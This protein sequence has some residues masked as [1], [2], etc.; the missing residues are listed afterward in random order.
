MWKR[1]APDCDPNW[2]WNST[3]CRAS[4][5]IGSKST[6]TPGLMVEGGKNSAKSPRPSN[7]VLTHSAPVIESVELPFRG[8]PQLS[9]KGPPNVS[10]D[11]SSIPTR[12]S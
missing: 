6:Q 11:P 3:M 10:F 9:V 12:C 5:L 7:A 4:R 2:I 1:C 8:T